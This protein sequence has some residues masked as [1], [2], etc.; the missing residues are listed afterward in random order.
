MCKFPEAIDRDYR[1]EEK[2]I[3]SDCNYKS[4]GYELS[5]WRHQLNI[6]PKTMVG[7]LIKSHQ[8]AH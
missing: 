3:K 7:E 1:A 2:T 5:V 8:T 6:V 4:I